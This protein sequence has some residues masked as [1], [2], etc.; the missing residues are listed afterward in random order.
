M[1]NEALNNTRSD[2]TGGA[3]SNF[4]RNFLVSFVSCISIGLLYPA[5]YCWKQRWV[6]QH[7]FI[8]G[9]KLVFDGTGAQLFGKYL[10]WMLLTIVTLGIYS[11]WLS[12][13]MEQWRVKHTHFEDGTAAE[14]SSRFDGGVLGL[15]GVKLLTGFVT[16]ITLS[17]GVYWAICYRERW[18]AK[19]T[20]IDGARLEFDGKGIQLFGKLFV[21]FLLTVIT[22]GIYSFW[23]AVKKQ[24]WL[25]S[26][27]H[28]EGTVA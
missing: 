20:V 11:F 8:N 5:M 1:S 21:W 28:I 7:T 18:Y 26:H 27:T 13:R 23:L 25:M 3:I 19:H 9:R 4:L 15:F 12:I 17:F 22:L 16:L 6:A 2:F 10:L 24:K 14:D